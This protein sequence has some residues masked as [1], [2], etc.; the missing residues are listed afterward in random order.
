MV[1]ENRMLTG[2]SAPKRNEVRRNGENCIMR[3]LMISI[4]TKY[5]SGDQMENNEMGEVCSAYWGE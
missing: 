4:L 5:C 3:S 1:F 2:I